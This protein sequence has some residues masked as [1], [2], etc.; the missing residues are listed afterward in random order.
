VTWFQLVKVRLTNLRSL[1]HPLIVLETRPVKTESFETQS[2]RYSGTA[3]LAMNCSSLVAVG[4][5]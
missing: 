1:R 3:F 2:R 5:M 4:P